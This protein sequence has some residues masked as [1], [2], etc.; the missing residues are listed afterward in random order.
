MATRFRVI[1]RVAIWWERTVG[2]SALGYVGF[3]VSDMAAW[4]DYAIGFLGLMDASASDDELRFRMDQRAWRIAV[5]KGERNDLAFAGFE[6][7]DAAALEAVAASLRAIGVETTR[8]VE[9]AKARGVSEL[10]C[11][12]DPSGNAIELYCG[13]TEVFPR[14][15]R[16]AA[17]VGGFLTGDQGLG[18][19]VLYTGNIAASLRFYQQ[20]LGFRLSDNIGMPAGKGRTMELTFLHCNP[21]HHTIALV[22]APV[23]RR[24]NHFML[25]VAALDDVGLAFDRAE[26]LG[27]KIANSLGRHTNDHMLSFY[28]FTPSGFEVEYGWG[29][30]T[31]GEDWV[32]VRH[33]APSI[34]G[35]KR[36]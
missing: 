3:E 32:T 20:G 26:R 16:S 29:A 10:L 33:N 18:H 17:G 35:H 34:W 24:L 5:S 1:L 15:F 22:P 9:L 8:D 12:R 19:L 31:V 25:Q 30:R 36:A 6:V 23:P 13:A 27:V 7:A 4:R 21:R 2:V 28:A 14:P 11:C